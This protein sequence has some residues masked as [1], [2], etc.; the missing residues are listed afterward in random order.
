MGY[1]TLGSE[2]ERVLSDFAPVYTVSLKTA[3]QGKR[4]PKYLGGNLVSWQDGWM[5][6]FQDGRFMPLS[7]LSSGSKETLPILT[8]LDYYEDQRRRSGNLLSEELYGD[9]LYFFDDF[10]IEEPEASV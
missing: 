8:V 4:V 7:E 10:T 5:L 6:A 2:P 9:R 3:S 1:K